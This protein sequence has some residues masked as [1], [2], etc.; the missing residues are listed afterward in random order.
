M[1][2]SRKDSLCDV[3]R[4][5]FVSTKPIFEFEGYFTQ[6]SLFRK[7]EQVLHRALIIYVFFLFLLFNCDNYFFL[8]EFIT[9]FVKK[10]THCHLMI[11]Q[12]FLF[13]I[14]QFHTIFFIYNLSRSCEFTYLCIVRP[15]KNKIDNKYYCPFQKGFF[16]VVFLNI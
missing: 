5:V 15:S 10:N 9:H 11:S 1:R 6:T 13:S 3:N 8:S 7:Y 2:V 12:V 14:I 4:N 16:V